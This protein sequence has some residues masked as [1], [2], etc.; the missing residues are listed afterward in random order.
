MLTKYDHVITSF[1]EFLSGYGYKKDG[2]IYKVEE[3]N[4]KVIAFFCHFGKGEGKAE[5]ICKALGG[6]ETE[7]EDTFS[8]K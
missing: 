1:D 8:L 5:E 6:R 3:G 4:D 7:Y 2:L